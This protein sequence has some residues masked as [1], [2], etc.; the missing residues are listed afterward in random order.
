MPILVQK[1][2]GTSVN[3]PQKRDQVLEKVTAAK[4]KGY[5]VVVVVSA[6][7]RKGEPYATDTFLGLLEEVGPGSSPRTKDLLASCGE[8]IST[9]LVAHA[10]EQKGYKA[11]PLTGFQAGI[12][13][14]DS[15]TNAEI[16]KVNAGRIHKEL[17]GG[18]IAVVAG[19]Q[20]ITEDGD[21]TTLGRGG[22]DTTALALGGALGAEMVEIYTDVPGIAFTDPRL[23]PEAP[24]LKSID[25][26]PMHILARAGAKVIHPR[27]VKAAINFKMPF[28]VKSTFTDEPGTLIGQKGEN[29]GGLY[30]IALTK[31]VLIVTV[32][33]EDERRTWQEKAVDDLF[34][35]G[36]SGGTVLAVPSGEVIP[37]GCTVSGDCDLITVV[38]EPGSGVTAEVVGAVLG[39]ARIETAGFFHL[40]SGGAWAVQA[41]RS[42]EAVRAIFAFA[43]Q[44]RAKEAI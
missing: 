23:L 2:G 21:I 5:D 4:D 31:N 14:N 12:G 35:R 27:A 10:L 38:W 1:F 11:C 34:Y 18:K 36:E 41:G 37:E 26:Y 33:G 44:K 39:D 29:F 8:I 9:C 6:M 32:K 40:P 43:G 28:L 42:Q 15:F 17:S 30:G 13:T 20:G 24:Y 19:F 3:T 25:F 16:M 7:G 22:S